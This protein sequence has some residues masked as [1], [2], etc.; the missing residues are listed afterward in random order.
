[1]YKSLI[2]LKSQNPRLNTGWTIGSREQWED[3]A[4]R[5][6][7]PPRCWSRTGGGRSGHRRLRTCSWAPESFASPPLAASRAS[8]FSPHLGRC[9]HTH[10]PFPTSSD[11][12]GS[13]G[14]DSRETKRFSGKAN[15]RGKAQGD[16]RIL[17]L[18][19][20]PVILRS[21]TGRV[22]SR[23]LNINART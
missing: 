21:I 11:S 12:F 4:R 13:I 20:V 15:S 8:L 7:S 10:P 6:W 16:D 23:F 3:K 22:G 5:V 14:R 9:P 18:F 1:M 2:S 19:W 17:I